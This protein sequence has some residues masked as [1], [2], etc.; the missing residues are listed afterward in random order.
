[1][2]LDT[3][4]SDILEYLESQGV[5]VFHS[6][7]RSPESALTAVF[8]DTDRRP[9]YR[10]FLAAAHAVGVRMLSLYCREFSEEMVDDAVEQ[11]DEAGLDREERRDLESQLRH[12]RQHIG[13]VCQLEIS[14]DHGDRVYIF[15]LRTEWYDEMNDILDRIEDAY[16]EAED[17][18]PLGGFYSNN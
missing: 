8:W 13:S 10:E 17:E 12:M 5:A 14:F 2:N 15:D 4:R 6:L 16:A 1:M 3:L 11:L 9:D 18:N 7:P